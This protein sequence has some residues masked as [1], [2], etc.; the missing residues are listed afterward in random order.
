MGVG[1]VDMTQNFFFKLNENKINLFRNIYSVSQIQCW[2]M[3]SLSLFNL[4]SWLLEIQLKL[5]L[6]DHNFFVLA[7]NDFISLKKNFNYVPHEL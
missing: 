4:E 2:W 3:E 6:T 1:G 5:F 7:V